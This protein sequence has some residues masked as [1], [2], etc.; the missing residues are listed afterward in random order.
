MDIIT[1]YL[2]I[3]YFNVGYEGNIILANLS[4]LS[5]FIL[6]MLFICWIII[7][8][9]YIAKTGYKKYWY[10]QNKILGV[11]GLFICMNNLY[12]IGVYL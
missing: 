11:M 7:N 9:K 4:L 8:Y 10:I 2:A 1:T 12:I 6:K 3:E 5:I